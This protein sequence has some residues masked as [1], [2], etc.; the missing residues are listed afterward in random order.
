MWFGFKISHKDSIY[1]ES[2]LPD[3]HTV[4]NDYLL[5]YC[6][7]ISPHSSNS[8][9]SGFDLKKEKPGME[10]ICTVNLQI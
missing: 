9:I 4:H 7:E 6:F 10:K 8:K 1:V 5:V 2:L 3:R